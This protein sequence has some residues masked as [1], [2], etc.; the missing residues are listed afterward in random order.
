MAHLA[1]EDDEYNGYKIPKGTTVMPNSWFVY[2]HC[3][4]VEYQLTETMQGHCV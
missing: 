3:L 4:Q 2:F 1:M